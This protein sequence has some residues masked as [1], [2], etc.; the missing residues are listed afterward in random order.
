M[1]CGDFHSVALTE[2]GELYSWGGGEMEVNL[3]Y[4][5]CFKV[6]AILIKD[7]VAMAP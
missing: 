2:K 4:S 5:Y 7:N 3:Q 1:D 6:E